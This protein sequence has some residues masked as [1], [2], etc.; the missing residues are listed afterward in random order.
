M[1]RHARSAPDL[2][3]QLAE[4]NATIAA[5][6]GGQVDAVLDGATHTPVLLAKAQEA[7]RISEERYRYIVETTSE[8]IWLIDAAHVT[9]FMNP[10]M[11]VM[12]GCDADLAAGRSP[13]EFMD[14]V[15]RAALSAYL[16]RPVAYQSEARFIRTDGTIMWALVDATPI[17][18]GDGRYGGSLA[19]VKDI[20]ERRRAAQAWNELSL[21]TQQRERMLSSMLSAMSDFAYIYDRAGRFLF[22]NQSLLTLWGISLEQAVGKNFF[23]LGY[24]EP[25]AT[26]LQRQVQEVFETA[27]PLTG[28]TVYTS[29]AGLAGHYEYIFTPV[30]APDGAVEFVAGSTR[31]ITARKQFE[32]ELVLRTQALERQAAMLAEQANLLELTP[33]AIVVR[34]IAGQIV[35][36]NRGAELLYGWR[37]DEAIGRDIRTL[38]RTEFA[39]PVVDIDAALLRDD[40]WAGEV[41]HHARD[42]RRLAVAT[43]WMVQRDAAGTPVHV[44][45]INEDITHRKQAEAVQRLLTERL[46][47]ATAVAQVGVWDWDLDRDTLTWD[48]T[49]FGIYGFT[50]V[51]PMPYQQWAAA[52]HSDD[53]P[54]VE[55]I[56]QRA[57]TDK[58]QG[59]A[60]FRIVRAD[61]TV[62]HVFAVER[63]V[64]DERAH[65]SRVVGVNIDITERRDA[66]ANLRTAR[67]A[68]EAAN[69]AKSEFLAN[70]SHEIRTPMNGVIGMT[71]LVLDSDLTTEQREHL[72]IA[73]SSAEALLGVINDILDFSKI[74]A[75]KLALDP[76]PFNIRDAVSE[77][78]SAVAWSAHKKGLEFIVD[79]DEAVPQRVTGDPGRWRQVLVNLLGNAIKFTGAGEVV[80]RVRREVS[81]AP[82]VVLHCAVQDTGIGIPLDRQHR[83]FEPFTQVDGSTTRG[84]GGTGLG[85][86][87]AA[88]LVALM[89]GSLSMESSAGHGSTFSFTARFQSADEL[90]PGPVVVDADLLQGMA[91]L[92]TDDNATNRR[93]LEEMLLGWRM[94]PT[95]AASAKEAL[96]VL[97]SAQ[98]AGRPI[99][100]VLT[101]ALMP[102][103]DGFALAQTIKA[104]PAVRGAMI[105]ILTSVGRPGDMA[106]CRELGIAAYLQKPIRRAELRSAV[107]LALQARVPLAR[108]EVVTRHLLRVARLSGR[109]LIVDDNAVNQL[110]ARRLLEKRGH[111]VAIANNGR[112]A[113]AILDAA[114]ADEFG[115]VLLDVQMPE[116]GG[117][118]CTTII[119]ARERTTGGH[120]PLIAMTAHAM[121]GDETQCLEAG[122][123]G[124]LSKPIDAES[125]YAIVEHHLAGSRAGGV[126]ER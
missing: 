13:S 126:E 83:I 106:R 105:V 114:A 34:D 2:E 39:E 53:L 44:L 14:D 94:V 77:T 32:Q 124:Y 18:D 85:L 121:A 90:V 52:V 20:T 74:E 92:V 81:A 40:Q 101:D 47:L 61:G 58:G 64:L 45:G 19:M 62:R 56:L 122:M 12:L 57:I 117:L 112:E 79:I 46:S 1:T 72:G 67:D 54:N 38:L 96:A 125:L 8:G 97:R 55:A 98:A 80:L 66:E 33:H 35:F 89:G 93:V 76:I 49:M 48:A 3:Q 123:D 23:D 59:T 16:E 113:L 10:R 63:V 95:L 104:D 9:V 24:P 119:R 7:L 28:E 31:D 109:I 5:L 103:V 86:T 118:E 65:V 11:A 68:A 27:K 26:Q 100:L 6:L 4:A 43:R 15:G 102:E 60:E 120:L 30:F 17:V 91:V 42:G 82:D 37:K 21:R 99:P 115:C 70:M 111:T 116:M 88:Q 36:W 108:A 71:E 29:G 69:Q 84:Y 110:V 50:P 22:A 73:K 41:T 51:T 87:I 78:A 75:R 25:S 107:L